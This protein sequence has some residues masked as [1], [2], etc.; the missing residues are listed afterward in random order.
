MQGGGFDEMEDGA[1]TRPSYT[2]VRPWLQVAAHEHLQLKR[3]EPPPMAAFLDPTPL[4][5]RSSAEQYFLAGSHLVDLQE[6]GRLG[7]I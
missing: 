1:Q 7:R 6:G 2:Q 5:E 4:P 3:R